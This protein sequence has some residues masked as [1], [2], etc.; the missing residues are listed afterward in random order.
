MQYIIFYVY[1]IY[2]H[3]H[4][5]IV[6]NK[7]KESMLLRENKCICKGLEEGKMKEKMVYLYFNFTK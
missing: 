7:T 2:I 3:I 5:Y 1:C 4:I 6:Y